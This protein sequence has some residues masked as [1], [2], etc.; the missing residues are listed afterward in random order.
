MYKYISLL[1]GIVMKL[2]DDIEDNPYLVFLKDNTFLEGL[3][4]LQYMF[5]TVVSMSNPIYLYIVYLENFLHFLVKMYHIYF[6]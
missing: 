5:T 4:G 6:Q 3:K 1:A 2:Y